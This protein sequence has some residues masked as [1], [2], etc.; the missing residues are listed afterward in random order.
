MF[1]ATG[2][3]GNDKFSATISKW[4]HFLS[5]F[6]N[7]CLFEGAYH[8]AFWPCWPGMAPPT[9]LLHVLDSTKY[10]FGY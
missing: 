10:V 4:C 8:C 6:C 7:I 5:Q 1:C 9:P 2:Q 3:C